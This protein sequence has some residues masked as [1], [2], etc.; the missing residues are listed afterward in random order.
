M[1][2]QS[3]YKKLTLLLVLVTAAILIAAT[4]AVPVY[5]DPYKLEYPDYFGNR[6]SIPASNPTTRQGVYLGRMLFY[7]T[8][9]SSS[10][11]ISC[12]SCHQQKLAF[13][14]GKAFSAGI[15]RPTRRNAM[16]LANLLWVRNFFLGRQGKRIG[17]PGKGPAWRSA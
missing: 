6:I 11:T 2:I 15:D 10:K 14:D 17:S 9:L 13:T 16:S 12:A 4:S 3:H 7:E 1:P 5:T 8:R